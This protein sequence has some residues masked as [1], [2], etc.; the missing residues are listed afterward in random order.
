MLFNLFFIL[1]L[2]LPKSNP[3]SK[4]SNPSQ[5]HQRK[6]KTNYHLSPKQHDPQ[7]KPQ[8]NLARPKQNDWS[9]EDSSR[10]SGGGGLAGIAGGEKGRSNPPRTTDPTQ[11]HQDWASLWSRWWLRPIWPTTHHAPRIVG[12]IS[13]THTLSLNLDQGLKCSND[14]KKKFKK[15]WFDDF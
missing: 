9:E 12:L 1:Q 3:S 4:N 2:V 5:E 8:Q 13:H 6:E 7:D 14:D 11:S 10:F 15:K